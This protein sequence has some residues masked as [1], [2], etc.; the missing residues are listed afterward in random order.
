MEPRSNKRGNYRP[1]VEMVDA[2]AASM[3]P[4]SNKRGNDEEIPIGWPEAFDASME[5]R[6]NK[7]G[8]MSRA[9]TSQSASISFN[10]AT[11]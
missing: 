6:S 5:P 7:R 11:L 8:N 3:E 4:R 2:I 9:A 1:T 10:G